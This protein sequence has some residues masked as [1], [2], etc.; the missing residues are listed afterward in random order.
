MI[1]HPSS[2]HHPSMIHHDPIIQFVHLGN[3]GQNPL[4]FCQNSLDPLHGGAAGYLDAGNGNRPWSSGLRG[5]APVALMV[6]LR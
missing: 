5:W 3:G 2:H 6:G 4:S 1:Q